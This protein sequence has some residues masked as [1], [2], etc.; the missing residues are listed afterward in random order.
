MYRNKIENI[1]VS[2]IKTVYHLKVVTPQT[3]KFLESIKSKKLET[4]IVKMFLT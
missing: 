1:I 2:N 4:K 3:M